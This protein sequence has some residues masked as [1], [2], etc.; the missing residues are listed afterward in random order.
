MKTANGMLNQSETL[1]KQ[2]RSASS[3]DLCHAAQASHETR[4]SMFTKLENYVVLLY[5]LGLSKYKSYCNVP[6]SC[7]YIHG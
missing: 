1:R 5:E 4:E 7:I 6:S 3:L 2:V